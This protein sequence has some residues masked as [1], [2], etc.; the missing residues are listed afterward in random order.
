[1]TSTPPGPYFHGGKPGLRPGDE[2][3]P[4]SRTRIL[5][6][7]EIRGQH[8]TENPACPACH[9]LA[10]QR[11]PIRPSDSRRVYITTTQNLA[12]TYAALW[13]LNPGRAGHG[14]VYRVHPGGTPE[15]DSFPGDPAG[16]WACTR[17]TVDQVITEDV[18]PDALAR[19]G[20]SRAT[21]NQTGKYLTHLEAERQRWRRLSEDE[22]RREVRR[23]A[24]LW[25]I[26][27]MPAALMRY[28]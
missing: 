13:T 8:E 10:G 9:R 21:I 25:G 28:L 16:Q 4:A 6:L 1:M 15:R 23:R 14:S 11:I 2:L 7:N 12:A 18:S 20:Y 26:G 24:R 27:G 22:I 17:A 19:I 3:L 5:T